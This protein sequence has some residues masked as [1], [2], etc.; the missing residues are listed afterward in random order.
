MELTKIGVF[1]IMLA[2]IAVVSTFSFDIVIV[3]SG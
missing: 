1:A 2:S 3:G